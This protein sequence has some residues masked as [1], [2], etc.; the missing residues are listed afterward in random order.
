MDFPEYITLVRRVMIVLVHMDMMV[1][2]YYAKGLNICRCSYLH[3]RGPANN[4]CLIKRGIS[5]DVKD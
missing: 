1:Q 2:I 3:L 5:R 4:L